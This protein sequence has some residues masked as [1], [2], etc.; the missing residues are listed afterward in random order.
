MKEQEPK[1]VWFVY[2]GK[3]T[4]C[5]KCGKHYCTCKERRDGTWEC[6]LPAT[7]YPEEIKNEI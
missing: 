1:G 4:T 6:Y 5:N 3:D 7:K 2:L